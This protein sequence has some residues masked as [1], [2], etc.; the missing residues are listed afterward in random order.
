V[1]GK[2]NQKI[3]TDELES[4]SKQSGESVESVPEKK[5]GCGGNGLHKRKVLSLE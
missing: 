4:I 3:K 2:K 5:K 1:G